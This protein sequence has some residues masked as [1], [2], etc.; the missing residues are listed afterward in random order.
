MW[1]RATENLSPGRN[2]KY[3]LWKALNRLRAE[4]ER[5]KKNLVRWKTG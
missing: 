1:K 5:T 3:G 2:L 4:V